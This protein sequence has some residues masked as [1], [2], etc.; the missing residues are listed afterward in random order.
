[1]KMKL[2]LNNDC[3]H[4]NSRVNKKKIWTGEGEYL[5]YRLKIKQFSQYEYSSNVGRT[6]LIVHKTSCHIS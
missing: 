1:M 4:G 6:N 2:N 3:N 5:D